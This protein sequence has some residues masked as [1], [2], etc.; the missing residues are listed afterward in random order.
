M[1][2]LLAYPAFFAT[3]LS[4]SGLTYLAWRKHK[5]HSYTLSEVAT[6][7]RRGL[8][9]FRSTLILCASLFAITMYG[10]VIPNIQY[11]VLHTIAWTLTIVGEILLA[12]YPAAN[13]TKRFHNI[14]AYIMGLAMIASALLFAASLSGIHAR[15]ELLLAILMCAFAITGIADRK[16]FIFYEL[17]V[18]YAAHISI[19]IAVVSLTS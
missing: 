3:I 5:P 2:P 18:I 17:G 15:S 9:Y 8:L 13:K 7:S 12:I 16:R 10:F 14:C 11:S 1:L 6:E 19:L 4:I